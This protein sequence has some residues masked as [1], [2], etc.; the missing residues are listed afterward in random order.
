[1]LNREV[2][3]VLEHILYEFGKEFSTSMHMQP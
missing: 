3:I 1:M 2:D